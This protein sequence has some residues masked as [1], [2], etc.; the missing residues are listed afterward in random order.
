MAQPYGIYVQWTSAV[1]LVSA[2]LSVLR[3]FGLLY[4]VDYLVP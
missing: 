1:I 2:V 3:F 4:C